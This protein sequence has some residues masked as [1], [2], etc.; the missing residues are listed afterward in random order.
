MNIL[1][2]ARTFTQPSTF[3]WT[4]RC[5]NGEFIGFIVVVNS[6]SAIDVARWTAALRFTY[7]IC[8]NVYEIIKC[9]HFIFVRRLI[10]IT[11]NSCRNYQRMFYF[12][13]R[14]RQTST[15]KWGNKS[16]FWGDFVDSLN[17]FRAN[18]KKKNR[19]PFFSCFVVCSFSF[20]FI[21]FNKKDLWIPVWTSF[22]TY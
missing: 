6:I 16:L 4:N 12:V 5:D 11:G 22:Q 7:L 3:I 14:L 1:T 19:I 15:W 21:C 9:Q 2:S 18:E 20:N 10:L 8:G 13:G 17:W